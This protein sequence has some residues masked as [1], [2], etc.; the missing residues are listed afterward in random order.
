MSTSTAIHNYYC[1]ICD[2]IAQ[3][4]KKI[5]NGAMTYFELVGSLRCAAE[6]YRMGREKEAQNL[7]SNAHRL[8]KNI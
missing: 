4:I 2:I 3:K 6:L 7:I 8:K 1:A 5:S